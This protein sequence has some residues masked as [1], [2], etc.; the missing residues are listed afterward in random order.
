MNSIALLPKKGSYIHTCT[1][2][3]AKLTLK[4]RYGSRLWK[5]L[6]MEP[7]L[8]N[9][10]WRCRCHFSIEQEVSSAAR[11]ESPMCWRL[12]LLGS[13]CL[14]AG[15]RKSSPSYVAYNCC[16]VHVLHVWTPSKEQWKSRFFDL[17]RACRQC[18]V[19][20]MSAPFAHIAVF[21]P[22]TSTAFA[23]RMKAL[24]FGS[25][26]SVHSFLRVAHSLWAILV[27]EFA[28]AWTNYFDDFVTFARLQSSW[29]VV[30]WGWRQSP[31]FFSTASVPWVSRS[32][33]R[34]CF[35]ELSPLTT[36]LVGKVTCCSCS[37]MS[38]PPRSLAVL[39]LW[40]FVGDFSLL[41]VSSQVA[42]PGSPSMWLP[43]MH[44]ACV[45]STLTIL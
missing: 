21:D 3:L 10:P 26:K 43:S 20:P 31:V 36:L 34:T 11:T 18:A 16:F 8:A 25:V 23:F 7:L 32:M 4:S 13:E 28:V 9:Q 41:L 33:S 37:M 42:S 40:D 15:R 2:V 6:T 19:N 35:G 17:K 1:L 12:H 29:L 30:C 14:C 27:K 45:A 38:S 39:T 5:K 24:P 44:I 22:T